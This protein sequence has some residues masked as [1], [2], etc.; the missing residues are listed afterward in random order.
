[1]LTGF[2]LIIRKIGFVAGV[3]LAALSVVLLSL[4]EGLHSAAFSLVGR[5]LSPGESS[6]AYRLFAK[7]TF[8]HYAT[9][10]FALASLLILHRIGTWPGATDDAAGQT[11]LLRRVS[12][13]ALFVVI[14]LIV[15]SLVF[16]VLLGQAWAF[17]VASSASAL[18]L[19][20]QLWLTAVVIVPFGRGQSLP[21]VR[22]AEIYPGLFG[23]VAVGLACGLLFLKRDD[24]GVAD[25]FMELSADQVRACYTYSFLITAA[26]VAL[27]VVIMLG[28]FGLSGWVLNRLGASTTAHLSVRFLVFSVVISFV[29]LRL[30]AYQ[31]AAEVDLLELRGTLRFN[32][33]YVALILPVLLLLSLKILYAYYPARLTAIPSPLPLILLPLAMLPVIWAVPLTGWIDRRRQHDRQAGRRFTLGWT[34]LHA[35]TLATLVLLGYLTLFG[36]IF[37]P[38]YT[39]CSSLKGL[40][41]KYLCLS[42]AGLCLYYVYRVAN[43]PL[44]TN[45]WVR[46][47]TGVAILVAAP[48]PFRFLHRNPEVKQSLIQFSEFPKIELDLVKSITGMGPLFRSGEPQRNNREHHPYPLPWT[49]TRGGERLLPEKTN[50]IVIVVDGLRGDVFGRVGCPRED[51]TPFLD[52]WTADECVFFERA[53][54]QGNGT[55]NSLPMLMGG[56]GDRRNLEPAVKQENMLYE[57]MV[58]DRIDRR[59]SF[60]GHGIRHLY[61][62]D[63]ED[64]KFVSLGVP[65]HLGFHDNDQSVRAADCIGS[66]KTHLA[67]RPE[68]ETFYVYI[69]LMDVHNDLYRK[70]EANNYGDRPKDLYDSNVNYLDHCMRDFVA[71]LEDTGRYDNT[72]IVFTSDHGEEFGEHLDTMHGHNMYEEA[73]RVPLIVRVPGLGGRTICT[74]VSTS[75]LTPTMLDL[76]GYRIDPPYDNPA[77]G[78][79]VKDLILDEGTHGPRFAERDLFL[80]ACFREKYALYREYRYK[81]VYWV[82]YESYTLFDLENDPRERRNVI[83][84]H[85]ELASDMKS[86]LLNQVRRIRGVEYKARLPWEE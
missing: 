11:G 80:S 72:V 75:D 20:A 61:P 4:S 35:L 64:P 33:L 27:L 59:Y 24:L 39:I 82:T 49:L 74:P 14:G 32:T 77:V 38:W 7:V 70:P 76:A 62:V 15:L 57:L 83:S 22:Q 28:A 79:S 36:I 53:Y 8:I 19:L 47:V 13:P 30:L 43:K 86:V 31:S 3:G 45:P 29:L 34:A 78:I 41:A 58:Q 68:D 65:Y 10:G 52:E 63:D 23:I 2:R 17:T 40:I 46:T 55:F 85:P 37:N 25:R 18:I 44:T 1:M 16:G 9:L 5:G 71:W 42:A 69:H 81:F 21:G 66:V 73:I 26:N 56:R 50:Y 67:E 54:A 6:L 60:L 51:I 84:E 48:L 12:G